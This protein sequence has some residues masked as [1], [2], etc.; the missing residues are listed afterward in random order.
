MPNMQEITVGLRFTADTQQAKA[1]LASLKTDLMNLSNLT[2]K[3]QFGNIMVKEL[4]EANIAAAKLKTQ[5]EAATNT[6]T[7]NLD[8]SKF[9]KQLQM[10]GTSLAQYKT[11]LESMGPAGQQA[12]LQLANSIQSAEMPL[13]RINKLFTGL[14]ENL[15]RTAGW[16]I[17]STAIHGFM[18]AIQGA[19]HY[20]QDLNESLNNIRIVTGKSVDDMKQ[21]A[22]Q[23]NRAAK[24][25]S[26][27]TKAYT[28]AS[29]IFYQQGLDGQEVEDRTNVVIKM[30]N[31]TGQSAETVSDQMTAVWNNFAKGGEDL[32]SFADKMTALGAVTASSTDEIAGGLE[33]FAAVAET[34][35]LSFDY[36]ASALAT[37]TSVT[38]QSEDTVGTALKTIFARLQ[39]LKLGESLEDG[40]DLNKYSSALLS[41]GVNIKDANGNLKD[42]D[43]IL[44]ELGVKWQNLAEDEKMALAQT[45]AGTRQYNQLMALMN[46]WDYFQENLSVS[47]NS[48]GT[49]QEQADIY[50][51]S[52]EAAQKRVKA[53][54]ESIYADLL[55]DE[56]FIDLT[57][58]LANILNF[59]DKLIDSMGGLPGLLSTISTLIFSLAG[60]KIAVG[61]KNMV[62]DIQ[63]LVTHGQAYIN[64]KNEAAQMGS[65]MAKEMMGSSDNV[66]Q[67]QAD[68]Y[69]KINNLQL[70]LTANAK[71]LNEIDLNHYNTL[72]QMYDAQTK[73]QIALEQQAK[74]A[75]ENHEAT[76]EFAV[77]ELSYYLKENE[78]I[79]QRRT[80][81]EE[82]RKQELKIQQEKISNKINSLEGNINNIYES[83]HY[84]STEKGKK[85]LSPEAE[86]RVAELKTRIEELK[87]LE[88]EINLQL[89]QKL[90]SNDDII[91]ADIENLERKTQLH[92]QIKAGEK[93]IAEIL[94]ERQTIQKEITKQETIRDDST[95]SIEQ[96]A[97]AEQKLQELESRR[98]QTE[99]KIKNILKELGF[100]EDEISN[101]LNTDKD[102]TI[103]L[104]NK[105]HILSSEIR[106][107]SDALKQII[108]DSE[109]DAETKKHLKD[110]IDEVVQATREETAADLLA[111]QGKEKIAQNYNKLQTAI[112]QATSKNNGWATSITN[113]ATTISRLSMTMTS[114]INIIKTFSDPD[115]SGWEKFSSIMMSLP[116]VLGGIV[117]IISK[118]VAGYNAMAVSMGSQNIIATTHIGTILAQAGAYGVLKNK[119]AQ[120]AIQD[121]LE[122]A[123]VKMNRIEREHANA[124]TEEEIALKQ[125]AILK[126]REE[127]IGLIENTLA[128]EANNKSKG[129]TGQATKIFDQGLVKEKAGL[130]DTVK[131]FKE[132]ISQHA[133]MIKGLGLIAAGIAVLVAAIAISIKLY[134]QQAEA[135]K[136]S[137]EQAKMIKKEADEAT[138]A[139]NNLK[140]TINDYQSAEEKLQGLVKGTKEFK[141]ALEEANDKA[142]EL[143]RNLPGLQYHYDENGM[144]KFD[145]DIEE[146]SKK[147]EEQKNKIRAS[148]LIAE[149]QAKDAQRKSDRVDFQRNTLTM[150]TDDILSDVGNILAST[151]TGAGSGALIGAGIGSLAPTGV[152][153]AA[154]AG[155]G[156][157]AGAITGAITGITASALIGN[158]SKNEDASIT[159]LEQ[160]VKQHPDFFASYGVGTDNYDA[161]KF[162][163]ALKNI[164][165]IT[166]SVAHS[167][168]Q[169]ATKL[170]EFVNQEA[171]IIEQ[172]KAILK[173]ALNESFSNNKS[174][175]DSDYKGYILNKAS[176]MID[177]ESD[178]YKQRR[179]EIHDLLLG[180]EDE[181]ATEYLKA[182]YGDDWQNYRITGKFGTNWTVEK[183]T[184]VDDTES[185]T[186]INGKN[187]LSQEDVVDIVTKNEFIEQ[188]N[189]N[190]AQW[191]EEAEIASEQLE[192]IGIGLSAERR[193]Q[194]EEEGKS[195]AYIENEEKRLLAVR[196]EILE[197]T[198]SGRMAD[199]SGLTFK[200]LDE[201][202]NT[203][204][205]LPVEINDDLQK[206]LEASIEAA[207]QAKK[208]ANLSAS[209]EYMTHREEIEAEDL[210][211]VLSAVEMTTEGFET[212]AKSIQNAN[213]ATGMSLDM[214]KSIA[215]ETLKT[216]AA[217]DKLSEIFSKNEDSIKELVDNQQDY[218]KGSKTLTGE[219]SELLAEM[220]KS[221]EDWLG[222]D[223]SADE[224]L[225]NL[226][227][228]QKASEGDAE[229]LKE[230]N[231]LAAQKMVAEFD[232][233]DNSKQEF[234]NFIDYIDSIDDNLTIGAKLEM[235]GQE[236][237]L[238]TL[239]EMLAAGKITAQEAANYLKRIGAEA[240]P[241]GTKEIDAGST[242]S[243]TEGTITVAGISIPY[244]NHAEVKNKLIV[245]QYK[246]SDFKYSGG[247]SNYTPTP[248]TGSGSGSKGTSGGGSGS[249][250]KTNKN[251][252]DEQDRYHE[253]NKTLDTISQRMDKL[254]AAKDR[255]F[256]RKHISA[257]Q[258]EEKELQNYIDVLKQK[259]EAVLENLKQDK[260][261]AASVG[262][263]FDENGNISNYNDIIATLVE[264]YNASDADNAD[265]IYDEK[266]QFLEQYE[267]TLELYN[268]LAQE[269]IDKYWE[270][271]DKKVE[272]ADYTLEIKV[273]LNE[274]DLKYIE[275]QLSQLEDKE[276]AQAEQIYLY[277]KQGDVNKLN[278]NQYE[279]HIRELL[280][281]AGATE[282]EIQL[283]LQ[284]NSSSLLDL[285]D[286]TSDIM[287]ELMDDFSNMIDEYDNYTE[288]YSQ[289]GETLIDLQEKYT[290]KFD[291][292][293][294]EMDF[295]ISEL[296]HYQNLI[297]ILGDNY[298][299]ISNELIQQMRQAT[300][301]GIEQRKKLLTNQLEMEKSNL[302]KA[303]QEQDKALSEGREK[304]YLYW[305]ERVEA[306]TDTVQ[307]I[308]QQI[309][310]AQ[311]EW[312]E[313]IKDNWNAAVDEM[314]KGIEE[315]TTGIYGSIDALSEA[316]DRQKTLSE[317][318][319]PEYEQAY[320]LNKL[321]RD[322]NKQI[323]NSQSVRTQQKLRDFQKEINDLQK[324]GQQLSKYD[325]DLLQKRYDLKVAEIALEEAQSAKNQVRLTRDANGGYAYVY[326][327]NEE[328]TSDAQQKYEDAL[329]NIEKFQVDSI[330]D[331]SSQLVQAY[332]DGM[333][334]IKAAQEAGK[335]EE[336]LQEIA[337]FYNS[338]MRFYQGEFDKILL[339]NKALTNDIVSTFGGMTDSI[340]NYTQDLV[341]DFN[342]TILGNILGDGYNSVDSWV[343]QI[344][345]LLGDPTLRTGAFGEIVKGNEELEKAIE[346]EVGKLNNILLGK[347]GLINEI[348]SGFDD[349]VKES[350]KVGSEGA[351]GFDA[352]ANSISEAWQKISSDLDGMI[353]KINN[354]ESSLKNLY[355]SANSTLEYADNATNVD[356]SGYTAQDTVQPT[357]SGDDDSGD[358]GKDYTASPNVNTTPF[359]TK[360]QLLSESYIWIN[361]TQHNH[362]YKY[363]NGSETKVED[364]VTSDH[365]QPDDTKVEESVDGGIRTLTVKV[366]RR[367]SKC[368]KNALDYERTFTQ[369]R[370]ELNKETKWAW[371]EGTYFDD[372]FKRDRGVISGWSQYNTS[373]TVG[374]SNNKQVIYN[375]SEIVK[376]AKNIGK[377]PSTSESILDNLIKNSG[378]Y[379]I[380]MRSGG[381]VGK[382]SNSVSAR[383]GLYTGEFGNEG[384][385]AILHEKELVLNKQDTQNMLNAVDLVR[386]LSNTIDLQALSTKFNQLQNVAAP[387]FQFNSAQTQDGAF[388][389]QVT[390]NAEFPG[391]ST[392]TEIEQAF[393]N[394]YLQASQ[395]VNRNYK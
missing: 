7:G 164:S 209:N 218:I 105:K 40:T 292:L 78:A 272:A 247:S 54:T 118:I 228:I 110:V 255:A 319:L 150:T 121:I 204:S 363:E 321:N 259:E 311:E 284:G 89:G 371:G 318:M 305:K 339:N 217:V 229:A 301:S 375:G 256:G 245:P 96:R 93:E 32:E 161:Q 48:A 31:V 382:Y 142:L 331:M 13:I 113:A 224:V 134:N 180:N 44:D 117:P 55:D 225:E 166:D 41:V 315:V 357:Y 112:A 133:G 241:S 348:T 324:S 286:L 285:Q 388:E 114:A 296:E 260:A 81:V 24:S 254:S 322:I 79:K 137:A 360:G 98:V 361:D 325:I 346:S 267:E 383:T 297:D 299:G 185:W 75:R 389:Q 151:A 269:Q 165:G 195:T 97:Q 42:M 99:T 343:N 146:A 226:D 328:K 208:E 271:I 95:A 9:N 333:K 43:D 379:Q 188:A 381:Y 266:K 283:F 23:A 198:S 66:G 323:D 183:K 12:F 194:L 58:N 174:Y 352:L 177:T 290:N 233:D 368:N 16:Q 22:D 367:C 3:G 176:N 213:K 206:S 354:V 320:E 330:N 205:D 88:D 47:Q 60:D 2:E 15:K 182:A 52:W 314:L 19:Y 264:E 163:E 202:K 329:Y 29:L 366:Y 327:A 393:N 145:S 184:K 100:Q 64:M 370:F 122:R 132:N 74:T 223:F 384:R 232:I 61:L 207:E 236:E 282:A 310:D 175:A 10:G 307:D 251:I 378:S 291:R 157:I 51:E 143:I 196:Q 244:K 365:D 239:N 250:S 82:Q 345:E 243:D 215:K 248:S 37:I 144:I 158:S 59:I 336:Q 313:T 73:Q 70:S 377:A 252:S 63:N 237:F 358:S 295:R 276:F 186:P 159:A 278:F 287:D 56:F 201:L 131:G 395:Y 4:N 72:I 179:S 139:Y 273:K 238:N 155:I 171:S 197:A 76:H 153:T 45:V 102:I 385:L 306:S 316:F 25:L 77:D 149:A 148:A 69:L 394:L 200:E 344:L 242:S 376:D 210:Q 349:I 342:E 90:E 300:L 46:N 334:A 172:Q 18:G 26:T 227:K 211:K 338:R 50:A 28:D 281:A 262:A 350:A 193:H 246:S 373:Y 353:Q 359:A 386:N 160:Y 261:N 364:H 103:A 14:W 30:A 124:T 138:E 347:D 109:L 129:V 33:K 189:Q 288:A 192:N 92:E 374:R 279:Q 108:N 86:A 270:L 326:T 65:Q 317:Q 38:R 304:D 265:E 21:F 36:A 337:D 39:G 104:A 289:I 62:F 214:A 125:A 128:Q 294:S 116:M 341:T 312:V 190:L 107:N 6:K 91:N 275:F 293:N 253:L 1:Q 235:E 219:Q 216:G 27:T 106:Q 156:A 101:I 390:I 111:S 303:K 49:L 83:A 380:S 249:S 35:G 20:A 355:N 191:A 221:L 80:L 332:S 258:A 135:A 5:L 17:S 119:T 203:L 8:L 362:T 222:V 387:Q 351:K 87:K 263:I 392:A 178:G 85:V 127:T 181:L 141:E 71:K 68:A 187:T 369:T 240:E 126:L 372:Q 280:S 67:A 257:I 168:A 169:N 57:N 84:S 308:T 302:E 274:F 154:G 356:Y 130:K 173:E 115:M 94:K 391:V 147:V 11:Q 120:A 277:G 170:E 231:Y 167:M 230:L 199:L 220:S 162:E 136:K 309:W 298:F 34:V 268:D 340:T 335:T 123:A 234:L 140:N 53:A 212:Y 152:T